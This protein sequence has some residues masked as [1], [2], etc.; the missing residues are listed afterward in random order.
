MLAVYYAIIQS[1]V[2]GFVNVSVGLF[3]ERYFED[4]DSAE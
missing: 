2:L 3:T 1:S 4:E